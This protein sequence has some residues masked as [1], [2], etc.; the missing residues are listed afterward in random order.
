[1][2]RPVGAAAAGRAP[3]VARMLEMELPVSAGTDATCV[4]SYNPWMCLAWRTTG[5]TLGGAR[6][7][8]TQNLLDRDT[9]LRM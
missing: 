9:A 4:A 1:M 5:R 8:P 2:R 3:P 7:Y 6:L